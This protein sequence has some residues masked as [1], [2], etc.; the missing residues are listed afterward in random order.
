MELKLLPRPDF[1]EFTL[2][3]EY[4]SLLTDDG[5]PI[6]TKL[7]QLLINQGLK[8]VVLS[9][10]Q[11]LFHQQPLPQNINRIMLENLSE[12]HLQ[13]KLSEIT[14][15]YGT[16][17]TFIHLHPRLLTSN[18]EEITYLKEEKAIVKHIFLIAKYLKQ[19]LKNAANFGRSCFCTVTRLDGAF[20]LSGK[21]NFNAI[22]GSLFGLTKS[23]KWEW[24]NVFC[25]AIDLNPVIDDKQSI[26]HI[27]AELHDPNIYITEVAYSSKGRKTLISTADSKHLLGF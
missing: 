13:E 7:A 9:F 20:G 10:P 24:Q 1:L 12:E 22:G 18:N 26:N 14:K 5:S 2:P 19:P 25:R 17:S 23:L 3:Q 8:V 11:S 4:I 16:V 15:N 27:I 6:T 21:G